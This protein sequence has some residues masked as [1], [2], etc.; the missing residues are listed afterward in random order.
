MSP[1]TPSSSLPK[2]IAMKKI[3]VTITGPSTAGKTVFSDVLKEKGFL[4]VVSTTTRPIRAGEVHGEHY[5]FVTKE[6]FKR[7]QANQELIEAVEYGGQ[8]Y[9]VSAFEA[10]RIFEK[11][12]PLVLVAEPSGT[13]QIAEYCQQ[14]GWDLI[15]VFVN[16]PLDVLMERILQRFAEDIQ[17]LDLGSEAYGKKLETYKKRIADIAGYEQENWVKP[18]YDKRHPYDFIFD[19]FNASNKEQATEEVLRAVHALQF[20]KKIKP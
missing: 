13:Q 20:G 10:E 15:R 4:P 3:I 17:G 6:E 1:S 18:A 16:N 11:G 19:A 12:Q 14:H 8:Y 9:G 5:Y 2:E 7:A